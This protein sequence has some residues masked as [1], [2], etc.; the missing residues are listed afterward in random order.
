MEL[1]Y[2]F[3]GSKG[4]RLTLGRFAPCV[5][6]MVAMLKRSIFLGIVEKHFG[7]IILGTT[8]A[9]AL[10]EETSLGRVQW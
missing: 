1:H 8:G 4:S 10:E 6:C 2:N 9:A 5:F 7:Q 3:E